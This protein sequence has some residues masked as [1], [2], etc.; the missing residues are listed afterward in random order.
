M[1]ENFTEDFLKYLKKY[2]EKRELKMNGIALAVNPYQPR[3]P[4][5]KRKKKW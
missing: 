5:G 2:L 3:K 1:K 4:H